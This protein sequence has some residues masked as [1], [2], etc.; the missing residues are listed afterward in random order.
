L[1]SNNFS[2]SK[3]KENA[4]EIVFSCHFGPDVSCSFERADDLKSL[5]P[6]AGR[7]VR[8]RQAWYPHEKNKLYRAEKALCEKIQLVN[9]STPRFQRSISSST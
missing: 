4:E 2:K 5:N 7:G 1:T 9:G 3:S 6:V 8:W